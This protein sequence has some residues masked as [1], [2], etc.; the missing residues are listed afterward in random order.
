[1]SPVCSR[2]LVSTVIDCPPV[3]L[4]PMK[5]EPPIAAKCKDKFLIQSTLITS[6]KET[7]PLHDIVR[8]FS[9]TARTLRL[10]I[11]SGMSLMEAKKQ[12]FINRSCELC[13]CRLR[14]RY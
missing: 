5:E 1:M 7:L 13:I 9:Q 11:Y 2:V 3:M 4:Q 12:R 10:T 14:A 8:L 6:E